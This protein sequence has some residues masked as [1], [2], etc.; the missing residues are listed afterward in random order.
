MSASGTSDDLDPLQRLEEAYA[1]GEDRPLGSF[2]GIMAVHSVLVGGAIAVA[3]RR[4]RLRTLSLADLAVAT[5]AT[6]KLSRLL[7]KDPVTSPLRAPFTRLE[8][9][10][11]PAEL[12]EE[13]RGDGLRHAL[14]E[15][16]TCPFCLGQWVAAAFC[17]GLVYLPGVTRMVAT[18]FTV[19]AGSDVLQFAYDRLED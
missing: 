1:P 7:A 16:V 3:A 8:G 10:T 11:G 13:V 12:S 4:G 15:L 19:H 2:I 9:T 18:I 5:I 6:Y 17:L 14:G